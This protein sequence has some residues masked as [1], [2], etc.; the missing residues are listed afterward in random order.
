MFSEETMIN[1]ADGTMKMIKDVKARDY[2]LNKLKNPVKVERNIKT[3]QQVVRKIIIDNGS[4]P[5]YITE[6]TLFLCVYNNGSFTSK[7]ANMDTI[8]KFN[9]K[10]KT[11]LK[12][13]SQESNINVLEYTPDLIRKDVYSLELLDQDNTSSYF[14]CN[15]IIST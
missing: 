8:Q 11:S 13:F 15:V 3:A 6:D 5:F 4:D 2:V 1:M 12:I 9:G 10:L 14:V 7:Y